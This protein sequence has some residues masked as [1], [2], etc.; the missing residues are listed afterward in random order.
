MTGIPYENIYG[1]KMSKKG[2]IPYIEMNGKQIPDSNLAI[3]FLK[4]YFRD[5]NP[6]V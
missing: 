6:K 3:E 2:Q 4:N 5:S 1:G